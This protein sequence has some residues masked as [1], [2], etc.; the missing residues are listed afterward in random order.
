MSKRRNPRASQLTR[1]FILGQLYEKG[2]TMNTARIRK[3][4]V[5]KA[6]AKRDMKAIRALLPPHG[7]R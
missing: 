7:D 2:H 3:L 1:G 6:T 4:G 5:S